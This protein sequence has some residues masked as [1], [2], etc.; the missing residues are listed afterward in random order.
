MCNGVSRVVYSVRIVHAI[1]YISRQ[2]INHLKRNKT[3]HT[4][5][6]VISHPINWATSPRFTTTIR[7]LF[8]ML[9]IDVGLVV[10]HVECYMEIC[11]WCLMTE[12]FVVYRMMYYVPLFT[13][14]DFHFLPGEKYS[15]YLNT[16]SFHT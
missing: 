16:I 1:V 10:L 5:K 14:C 3:K 13:F 4:K 11:D 6:D 12:S 8:I 2:H 7:G 15:F 9:Y